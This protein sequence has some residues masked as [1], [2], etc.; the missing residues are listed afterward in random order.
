MRLNYIGF[1]LSKEYHAVAVQRAAAE[2]GAIAE[3]ELLAETAAT[4]EDWMA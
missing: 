2:A 1:E 4:A 3:A